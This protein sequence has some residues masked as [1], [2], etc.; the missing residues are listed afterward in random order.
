MVAGQSGLIKDGLVSAD[1]TPVSSLNDGTSII[2]NWQANVE[3][4]AVVVN[5]SIVTISLGL[6]LEAGLE[7]GLEKS[8]RISCKGLGQGSCW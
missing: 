1:E 8:F 3:D 7:W 4:L 2:F 5:I 6:T